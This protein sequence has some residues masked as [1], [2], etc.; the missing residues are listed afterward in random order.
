MECYVDSVFHR[1]PVVA[2]LIGAGA[3]VAGW[4]VRLSD[5]SEV[6]AS[7]LLNSPQLLNP[8]NSTQRVV[9]CSKD[10]SGSDIKIEML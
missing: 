7:D 3:D 8:T 10:G 1:K 2:L 9:E 6:F 4:R 5:G